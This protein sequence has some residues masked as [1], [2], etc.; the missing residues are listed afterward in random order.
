M[1]KNATE[2]AIAVRKAQAQ[3]KGIRAGSEVIVTADTDGDPYTRRVG[4]RA[5]VVVDESLEGRGV[6]LRYAGDGERHICSGNGLEV[7]AAS[8]GVT[9]TRPYLSYRRS[10][11]RLIIYKR[12]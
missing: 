4:S 1:L 10:K 6:I 3:L 2:A 7:F 11:R 12:R 9:A 8:V 5:P